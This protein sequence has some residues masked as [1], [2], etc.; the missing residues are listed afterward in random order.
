MNG[1]CCQTQQ[2]HGVEKS[3]NV[4][5]NNRNSTSSTNSSQTSSGFESSKVA[6][7]PGP[8]PQERGSWLNNLTTLAN[9]FSHGV[10]LFMTTPWSNHRYNGHLALLVWYEP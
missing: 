3:N 5:Y 8:L 6:N 10:N 1:R 2:P 7:F 4:N 9:Q